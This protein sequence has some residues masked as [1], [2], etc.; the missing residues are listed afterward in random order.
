MNLFKIFFKR[1]TFSLSL[2]KEQKELLECFI[3]NKPDFENW[4]LLHPIQKIRFQFYYPTAIDFYYSDFKLF[5][6]Y[7]KKTDHDN[8]ELT[9]LKI[10]E[11]NFDSIRC[12]SWSPF[13]EVMMDFLTSL[14]ESKK[15]ALFEKRK[16]L[17]EYEKLCSKKA[18]TQEEAK[19]Y[20]GTVSSLLPR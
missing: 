1:K 17:F 6:A 8:I 19:Q 4:V 16:L 13:E 9:E 10:S 12:F 15:I 14:Q 3:Q 5:T 20:L 2:K 18:A 11:A 7:F